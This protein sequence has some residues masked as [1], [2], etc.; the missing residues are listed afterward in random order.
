M[1]VNSNNPIVQALRWAIFQESGLKASMLFKTGTTYT[2]IMQEYYSKANPEFV[3]ITYGPG[4]PR[5]EHTN[6]ERID[7]T[8][9]EQCIRIY[10]KFL[11]KFLE[12]YQKFQMRKETALT[13]EISLA[14]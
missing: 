5:L 10:D 9:Y 7:L 13:N 14:L 3:C 4:D 6:H 12:I 2:N 11:L 8:E 1:L